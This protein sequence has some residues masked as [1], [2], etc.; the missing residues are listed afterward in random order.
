MNK[1]K[2][3][4]TISRWYQGDE[5]RGASFVCQSQLCLPGGGDLHS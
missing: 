1:A 5:V 2:H 4:S 3:V